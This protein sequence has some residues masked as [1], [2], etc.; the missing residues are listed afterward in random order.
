MRLV[1]LAALLVL[2]ALAAYLGRLVLAQARERRLQR[3]LAAATWRRTEYVDD[4]GVTHVV[5]RRSVRGPDGREYLADHDRAVS[6]IPA[7][8]PDFDDR[9]ARARLEADL[10]SGR[11]NYRRR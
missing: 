2:A 1:D 5:L 7:D 6:A 4:E 8:A 3:R 10:S 9:L 11:T